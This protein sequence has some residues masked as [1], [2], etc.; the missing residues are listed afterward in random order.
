MM[1]VNHA[2]FLVSVFLAAQYSGGGIMRGA[3]IMDMM[4]PTMFL[5]SNSW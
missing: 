4:M 1:T 5:R 3:V 2:S